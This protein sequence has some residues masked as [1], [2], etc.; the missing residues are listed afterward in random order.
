MSL[1]PDAIVDRRRMRRKLTFWRV[2]ALVVALLAIG[3]A[4]IFFVPGG[5]LMP[6]GAYISR[7]KVQGLIRGNQN[8]VDALTRLGQ[9]RAKAVIVH[10]DSPGGTT[11]GSEQLYDALRDLQSKKPMV[12]V[13]DGIAASGAYI[14]ALSADHIIA[15]ETSLVGSIGVLFQYP[16][17]TDVLKT[18]G[19]KVEEVKSSPLKAAPNGFEPTSPEARK[20]IEAIVLDSYAWFKDLVKDRRKMDDAQVTRVA[21]GRVFTGRQAAGLKL[22][23]GLGNEKAALAWLEKEKSVPAN[24]PVRDYSLQPRFSELSF[25]HVAAWTFEAV[26]LS[27]IAHR[28]EEWGAVQAVERL[29]LD[30]LLAL[31]HPPSTN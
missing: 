25:L 2:S 11:A 21:D 5:R 24:T 9:S 28:I 26:G 6:P 29:N 30:G 10:I 19:I 3:G 14:A 8:R 22:V 7:I 12:V 13:V 1:D 15:N 18:I 23:D 27:A 31:W 4:A 17:F 16:N 20:A